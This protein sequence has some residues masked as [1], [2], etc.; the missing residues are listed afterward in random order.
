MTRNNLFELH[1]LD[2]L[3]HVCALQENR[4]R[5]ASCPEIRI[6]IVVHQKTDFWMNFV[7]ISYLFFSQVSPFDR[8]KNL[9]QTLSLANFPFSI[10]PQRFCHCSIWT[11][12]SAV[13][14]P[15]DVR[16]STSPQNGNHSWSC[17]TSILEDAIFPEGVIAS[18]SEVILARPSQHSTT[19]TF[20]SGT[21]GPRWFS[22][23]L[24]HERIRRRI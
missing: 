24:P 19:R 4:L 17:R 18:S 1:T 9:R 14:Q 15:D 8:D 11:I 12:S 3:R 10:R 16:M 20:T 5:R 6:P 23:T 21:S 2:W 7:P 22:L 13:R